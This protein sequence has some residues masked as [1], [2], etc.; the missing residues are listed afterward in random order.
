MT[1]LADTLFAMLLTVNVTSSPADTETQDEQVVRLRTIADD[2]AFVANDEPRDALLI[3]AVAQHESGFNQRIDIGPCWR[4][5]DGKGAQCDHGH[6]AC[7]MQ[8]LTFDSKFRKA[9]FAD[10][11]LCFSY[12]L[13]AL[14]HSRLAEC[15]GEPFQ[16]VSYAG[17]SCERGAAGSKELFAY[18]LAWQTKYETMPR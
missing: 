13:H 18:W 1:T 16:F 15:P 7:M 9:L 12:A 6:S 17:G 5:E 3:L 4:G 10:R 2:A 8:I 14:K 11:R